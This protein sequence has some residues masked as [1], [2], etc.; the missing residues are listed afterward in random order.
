MARMAVPALVGG[1]HHLPAKQPRNSAALLLAAAF[2]TRLQQ[3]PPSNK[4][5]EQWAGP[6]RC[7]LSTCVLTLKGACPVTLPLVVWSQNL[8]A[9]ATLPRSPTSGWL[10][11]V[12]RVE[13]QL[14]KATWV[15]VGSAAR[16]LLERE[17]GRGL[18]GMTS[19][20]GM[21]E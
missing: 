9:T 11:T 21:C 3:Q 18:R 13:P 2:Q 5:G 10:S 19:E 14:L 4:Q 17:P 7:G 6:H 20:R 1:G 12:T 8:R 15:T 16:W